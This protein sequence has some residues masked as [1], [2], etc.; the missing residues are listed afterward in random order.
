[1]GSRMWTE[2]RMYEVSTDTRIAQPGGIPPAVF[3]FHVQDLLRGNMEK[4][5]KFSF[6]QTG[7]A[8][9]IKVT[10]WIKLDMEGMVY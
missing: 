7:H 6:M 5:E 8:L 3:D 1:M 4:R 2:S 10:G 9:T